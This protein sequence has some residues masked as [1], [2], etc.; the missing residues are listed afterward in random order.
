[1]AGS[2]ASWMC[3]SPPVRKSAR[4][5][6]PARLPGELPCATDRASVFRGRS[7]S[8]V[9]VRGPLGPSAG[10]ASPT[11]RTAPP[12]PDRLLS[13]SDRRSEITL[14]N[15]TS[16]RHRAPQ[17]CCSATNAATGA[18][19]SRPQAQRAHVAR[20][21]QPAS[22]EAAGPQRSPRR[23][24]PRNYPRQPR[25]TRRRRRRLARHFS[26]PPSPA[27]PSLEEPI[28]GQRRARHAL[29]TR[30][31][32]RRGSAGRVPGRFV[33]TRGLPHFRLGPPAPAHGREALRLPA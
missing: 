15:T 12:H 9:N 20:P 2:P 8:N 7:E 6:R 5:A 11:P 22:A 32:E 29:V 13:P 3:A 18:R 27:A 1:M 10:P 26:R 19:A 16:E 14:S 23:T 33:P 21:Q 4:P 17:P 31:V 24:A 25:R 30:A 28:V